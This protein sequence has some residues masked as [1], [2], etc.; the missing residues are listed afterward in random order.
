[1]HDLMN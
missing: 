1:M